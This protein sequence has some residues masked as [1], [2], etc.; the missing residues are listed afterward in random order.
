MLKKATTEYKD[1]CL[2]TITNSSDA[3][4]IGSK[5]VFFENGDCFP[6]NGFPLF[7]EDSLSGKCLALLNKGKSRAVVFDEDG[8]NFECF[9]DV[10]P[11]PSHLIIAGAGHVCEPVAKLGCML[12]FYV[13]VIDDRPEFANTERFPDVDKVVCESFLRYFKNVPLTCKTYILLLTRGHRFDVL[14][15]QELLGRDSQ[16]AYIGMIGSRRRI[17]GVFEQLKEEFP[18]ERLSQIYTPV[19][20]DIGAETPEEIAVSIMAEIL[21]VKNGRSGESISKDIRKLA[22]LGFRELEK[23]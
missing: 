16:P 4:T 3:S 19:G 14:S 8:V 6:G 18:V 7:L 9:I 12:G 20:L 17:S 10:Y 21:K 5:A 22:P 13:T 23:K 1:A 11:S 15:L 2:V